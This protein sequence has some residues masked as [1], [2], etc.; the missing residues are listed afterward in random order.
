[1]GEPPRG[2]VL[3]VSF[4]TC[5]LT[6]EAIGS[7]VGESSVEIIVVDNASADDSARAISERF[8]SVR[9]IRSEIN[10]GFAGGVNRAAQ[11]AREL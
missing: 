4:N 8:P 5:Q 1:V 11:C 6:L 2:S 10:V 9:L 3:S 7:V